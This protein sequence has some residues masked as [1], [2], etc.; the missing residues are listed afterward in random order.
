MFTR[1]FFLLWSTAVIIHNAQTAEACA[2]AMLFSSHEQIVLLCAV[3]ALLVVCNIYALLRLPGLSVS[4]VWVVSSVLYMHQ[5]ITV[6]PELSPA[7]IGLP[8]LTTFVWSQIAVLF[9]GHMWRISRSLER[10]GEYIDV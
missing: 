7:W 5:A 10:T 4:V 6:L 2:W 9:S 1:I 3:H 8:D